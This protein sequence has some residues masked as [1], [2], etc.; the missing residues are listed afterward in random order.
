M[1]T[2]VHVG[3]NVTVNEQAVEAKTDAITSVLEA[4]AELNTDE[5]TLRHALDKLDG[6]GRSSPDGTHIEGCRIS[7]NPRE[8]SR[9]EHA[10]QATASET[11]P[12]DA[13]SEEENTV[14]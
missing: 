9:T 5:T 4:G 12:I 1:S 2:A 14:A 8:E 11:A 7:M 6:V 13:S 10:G 3:D